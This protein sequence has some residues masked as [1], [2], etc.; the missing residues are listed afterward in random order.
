MA[1]TGFSEENRPSNI[2]KNIANQ[3]EFSPKFGIAPENP[4]FSEYQ[5]R[6][7]VSQTASSP[8]GHRSGLI[9]SPVDLSHLKHIPVADVYASASAST[10]TSYDLRTLNRVTPV[11]NQGSAG[12]CWTFATYGSLESYLMPGE[13]WSFSENNIKNLLSSANVPKGFDRGPNDG[14]NFLMSTAYLAR[15]SGPVDTRDEP[16][17]A[18]S[19]F[20]SSEIG[21]P[22]YKNAQNVTF[23]PNRN[24]PTDNLALKEAIINYGA[25]AATMYFDPYNT[26]NYNQNTYSYYYNGATS[27]DHAVTIVGWVDSFSKN[28]FSQTPPGDGAF[29]IK[30]SWGTT[31]A[32]W[33]NVNNNNGYFY[34]SYYDSNIGYDMNTL[35]TAENPKDYTN[36]YQYDP[37]GWTSS[38]GYGKP[39]GWGAN[40]FTAKS[41]EVLKAVSFYTTDLNCNYVINIYNNTGS[42]PINQTGPVL[43]QSGAIPN[44]GYHT[45]PLN[46]GIKLEAGQNFSVVL[47]LTN[48]NYQY[49]IAIETPISNY[50]SQA[51]ANALESFVSSDGNK[52]T[53]I[54]TIYP[55][56]DVCIKAFTNPQA[57]TSNYTPTITWSNPADIIS[58]IPLS[59]VQLDASASVPGTFV[60]TPPAGTV[61]SVG[62]HQ[63]LNTTFTPN[64]TANYTT[65]SAAVSINVL[66]PVVAYITNS[67]DRTVS[68]I[69]ITNNS[70]AVMMS[71]GSYPTGVA[72]TSDRIKVYVANYGG[73]NVSVI[74]TATN[75]VTATVNVGK[76][77]EGVAVN[78]NGTKVYVANYGS[79]NVSVINTTTNTIT[80]TVPVG[81][82]PIGVAVNPDGTK[83]YVANYVDGTVSVINTTTNTVAATVLVR[84]YPYEVAV[85][86]DGTKVYVANYV[87]SGTISVINTANNTVTATVPVGKYPE[88]VA[89]NPNGSKVYVANHNSNTVSVINTTTNKVVATVNVGTNPVGVALTPDGTNLYVTNQNGNDV[90]VINT[91]T[92]TVTVTLPVGTYPIALGEFISGK[93]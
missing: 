73:N 17:S 8:V 64:D 19:S 23:L 74:D 39:T 24:G 51:T 89:V 53:D 83:V 34:V 36:I 12:V 41:D 55:N 88:G 57:P 45:V 71:V 92:N 66:E 85:S 22:V 13:T 10:P 46:F 82:S 20:S 35:F 44:A 2:H 65:A 14:G 80:A 93:I 59:N 28:N 37:L 69:N 86:P 68:V 70:I 49:P 90:S 18:T 78:P 1:Y 84:N 87:N 54:T 40:I 33:G 31:S 38:Y 3:T 7:L 50:C 29:I 30:N 5:N 6:K 48:P 77:P 15:G 26:T 43:T 32:D 11:E 42:K 60:Y 62:S 58:G 81:S 25:V 75:N 61:L 79:N 21:L 52:W 56:T 47:K 16:Y 27:S 72:V 4:R 67:G 76:G 91:T 63:K 9:P